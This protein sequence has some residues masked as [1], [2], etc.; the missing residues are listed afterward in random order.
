M[1]KTFSTTN[2]TVLIIPVLYAF[3]FEIV[4]FTPPLLSLKDYPNSA[5][6]FPEVIYRL[7][8]I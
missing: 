7:N 3:H 8:Y 4:F 1:S 6:F 5:L 2:D